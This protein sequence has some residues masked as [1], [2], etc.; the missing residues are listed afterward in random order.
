MEGNADFVRQAAGSRWDDGCCDDWR[1]G[2][3]GRLTVIGRTA[4]NDALAEKPE[5]RYQTKIED[6]SGRSEFGRS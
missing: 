5:L 2:S 1:I 6:C 3:R 4:A